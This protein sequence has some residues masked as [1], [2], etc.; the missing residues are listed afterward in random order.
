MQRCGSDLL[1]IC[2]RT[3]PSQPVNSLFALVTV[4]HNSGTDNNMEVSN[5][6][7]RQ[8]LFR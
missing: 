7:A 8:S 1:V 3:Q 2:V 5:Q 4:F 6:P